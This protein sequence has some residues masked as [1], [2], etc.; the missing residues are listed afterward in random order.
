MNHEHLFSAAMST[1]YTVRIKTGDKK[2]AG[3]DA[4]VFMTLYGTKDDT[5]AVF[6][7]GHINPRWCVWITNPSLLYVGIINM[8][9][10]KTHKNKFERG[11]I[12]EFIVE[13]VD[14]GPLK[15]LRIG[16]DNRGKFKKENVWEVQVQINMF[17]HSRVVSMFKEAD[18]PAGSL[19]GWKLMLHLW[20][21]GSASP[22]D[23]GWTKGRMMEPSSG[24]FFLILFKL[25]S[26]H[27]VNR[28]AINI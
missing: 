5:G 23:A 8:K 19:T 24:I 11:L 27:H 17:N 20:G 4:N 25:S 2:Y 3:T 14:I 12:D 22:A 6:I 7:L 9:A 1:T 21:R 10:S 13:A 18:P 28:S 26:T 15:K 16:H